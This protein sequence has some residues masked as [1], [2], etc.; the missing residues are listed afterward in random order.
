MQTELSLAPLFKKLEAGLRGTQPEP[1]ELEGL[2]VILLE[3]EDYLERSRA[4]LDRARNK[5]T[6]RRQV[7]RL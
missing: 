7:P 1:P 4:K 6:C 2:W 5:S 3:L